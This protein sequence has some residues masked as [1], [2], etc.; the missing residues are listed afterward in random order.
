MKSHELLKDLFE[1]HNPK[2]VAD[3]IGVSVSTIYK[4]AEDPKISGTPNPLDRVLQIC[5]ATNDLRPLEWLCEELLP[6][7]DRDPVWDKPMFL[8]D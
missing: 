1:K 7:T 6:K 8:P 5:K 3:K 4:W 2:E